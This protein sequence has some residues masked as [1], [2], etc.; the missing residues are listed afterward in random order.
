MW[1]YSSSI[2]LEGGTD[3]RYMAGYLLN[4]SLDWQGKGRVH[5]L[6]QD[7][8]PAIYL[9]SLLRCITVD[10]NAGRSVELLHHQRPVNSTGD[11]DR[12]CWASLHQLSISK[13]FPTLCSSSLHATL[14]AVQFPRLPAPYSILP[15]MRTNIASGDDSFSSECRTD[16]PFA[17]HIF[18]A[19]HDT[20]SWA[21]WQKDPK[22]YC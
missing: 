7:I 9:A 21:S 10:C 14:I 2:Y 12:R 15:K 5:G 3:C 13:T 1:W 20:H 17:N 19:H 22:Y 11:H 18:L 8:G 4:S 6:S 16:L